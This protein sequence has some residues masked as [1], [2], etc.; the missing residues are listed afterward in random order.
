MTLSIITCFFLSLI[1][2][3]IL[4][5]SPLLLGLWVLLISLSFTS[6]LGLISSSWLAIFLFLIYVGGLLVI[7]SYFVALVPNQI[8]EGNNIF[9]ILLITLTALL[10][11]LFNTPIL[12]T[13]QTSSLPQTLITALYYPTNIPTLTLLAITLFFALVAVVKIC[14]KSNA[15]LRPFA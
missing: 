4:A 12:F 15:P 1:L 9:Y 6:L 13:S 14:A 3:L 7:F 5:N 10:I 11:I 2:S 8:L